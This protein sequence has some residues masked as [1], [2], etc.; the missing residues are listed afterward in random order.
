M[1]PK[2]NT[3][4]DLQKKVASCRSNLLAVVLFTVVNIVLLMLDTG[5]YF[6]FSA[7][8]PYYLTAFGIGMDLGMAGMGYDSHVFTIIALVLSAVVLG[9]LMLS[10]GLSKKKGG[11]LICGFVVMILDTLVLLGVSLMDPE[12]FASNILDFVFHAWV[13]ISLGMGM[14]A[15]KK[16]KEMPETHPA[17]VYDDLA[18]SVKGEEFDF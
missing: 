12:I 18:N 4:E 16:L 15:N 7:S 9:L 6:L 13:L 3:R 8:G 11:W 1:Q 10:W 5:T 14:S 2:Q 17:P